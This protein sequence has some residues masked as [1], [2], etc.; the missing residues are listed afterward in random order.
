[1][2]I[3]KSKLNTIKTYVV[4]DKGYRIVYYYEKYHEA[5][6]GLY[7]K[8]IEDFANFFK[9]DKETIRFK[10]IEDILNKF[11]DLNPKALG[12]AIYDINQ[13]CIEKK[14]KKDIKKINNSPVYKEELIYDYNDKIV[15]EGYRIIYFENDDK[16]SIGAYC[17]TIEGYMMDFV[18]Y[19]PIIDDDDIP[20]FISID[21]LLS[22]YLKSLKDISAVALYK[23]DGTCVQKKER[24]SIK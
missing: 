12:V 19:E 5:P 18:E 9:N 2:N 22:R 8:K 20:P 11:L 6:Q 15:D 13:K 3:D 23:I 4:Y 21:D 16:Y 14:V 24:Q 1:M 7:A 17:K 10:D